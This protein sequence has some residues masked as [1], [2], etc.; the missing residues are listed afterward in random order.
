VIPTALFIAALFLAL[1][2]EAQHNG[3]VLLGWAV[4]LIA[5]GL[6]WGWLRL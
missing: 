1:V 2:E 6:L 5:L 4:V 3:R